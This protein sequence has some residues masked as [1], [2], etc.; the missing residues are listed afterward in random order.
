VELEP[1]VVGAVAEGRVLAGAPAVGG[2]VVVVS[3]VFASGGVVAAAVVT[4]IVE[5]AGGGPESP[6]SL[7][8][9]AARTPSARAT[10]TAATISGAFQFGAA[11]RRV[12]AAA[13][14]R[15]HH[16][17]SLRNGVPQSGQASAGKPLPVAPPTPGPT[18]TAELAVLT[19]L[20]PEGELSPSIPRAC[21]LPALISRTP[22]LSPG[23]PPAGLGF[24]RRGWLSLP[25][26]R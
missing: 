24:W 26:R 9:A 14:Q 23:V 21:R 13:P 8:S 19:R 15:R 3:V 18:P 12:L 10:I 5:A 11:A 2:V 6:A 1:V 17:C 7:T 20:G 4:V 16:S 22:P 25:A